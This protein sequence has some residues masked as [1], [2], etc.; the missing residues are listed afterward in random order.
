M[1]IAGVLNQCMIEEEMFEA[2]SNFSSVSSAQSLS[3][4]YVMTMTTK[5][6]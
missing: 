6:H 1:Y 4:H 2:H 3:L 5:L